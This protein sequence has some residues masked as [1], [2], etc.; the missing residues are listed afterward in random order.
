MVE[1]KNPLY[2][3]QTGVTEEED[4]TNEKNRIDFPEDKGEEYKERYNLREV[5]GYN[6]C[7]KAIEI[8]ES[9][10]YGEYVV[11]RTKKNNEFYTFSK[12]VLNV[13]YWIDQQNREGKMVTAKVEIERNQ[14]Y[15]T[16]PKRKRGEE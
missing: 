16:S 10:R 8:R 13:V 7:I 12:R 1:E 3:E 15:F 4:S 9:Q 5:V 11:L 14:V 6:I 2:I